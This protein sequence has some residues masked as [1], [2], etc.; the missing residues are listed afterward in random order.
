MKKYYAVNS[1]PPREVS[2]EIAARQAKEKRVVSETL[3]TALQ[4]G[5]NVGLYDGEEHVVKDCS[6][7]QPVLKAIMS[8]DEETIHFYKNGKSFGWVSL[9]Y[10]NDDGYDVIADNS[11]NIE[12]TMQKVQSVVNELQSHE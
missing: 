9:V 5:Y 10:G 2:R 6:T 11:I 3:K 12:E 8:V 7:Y 1:N 4:D